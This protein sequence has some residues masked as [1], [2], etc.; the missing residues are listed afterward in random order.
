MHVR[1][2]KSLALSASLPPPQEQLLLESMFEVPGS[3]VSAVYITKETVLEQTP[4]LY[5]YDARQQNEE[6]QTNSLQVGSANS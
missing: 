3:E 6:Q 4:P 1:P 2:S 5:Q